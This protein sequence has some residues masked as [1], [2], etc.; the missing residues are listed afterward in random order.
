MSKFIGA[1]S[2]MVN[3]YKFSVVL[4]L[5]QFLGKKIYLGYKDLPLTHSSSTAKTIAA[6]FWGVGCL[7]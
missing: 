4:G 7:R 3:P 6:P 2:F 1:V 5:P